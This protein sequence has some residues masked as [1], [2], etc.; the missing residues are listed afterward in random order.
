[1]A[2]E[3]TRTEAVHEQ[4]RDDILAG[5]LA[6]GSRLRFAD[7]SDWYGASMGVT[8]EAL[9]R[10]CE[11]GLVV[12]EP[13]QGFRVITLS[14]SDLVD[15]TETRCHLEGTALALAIEYGGLDWESNLLAAHHG[16]AR[17][18]IITDA[19]TLSPDWVT[20]HA[21]F[22]SALIDGCPNMRL[23]ALAA[24]Q[25]DTAE[26]YRHWSSNETRDTA[27]EH[28][29]LCEAVL[30]RDSVEACRL[31][32][33]H[34]VE[35]ARILLIAAPHVDPVSLARLARCTAVTPVTVVSLRNER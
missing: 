34:L 17:T 10:L 24:T 2:R 30:A 12:S 5:R 27:G 3:L 7:L 11:Q 22:H 23:K 26:V 14:A 32:T 4:L 6:P 8:R 28:R 15:L 33:E 16:L 13:Q 31:L 18:R 19:G 21:R 29:R 9:T 1:M 20:A 25:R 35:T